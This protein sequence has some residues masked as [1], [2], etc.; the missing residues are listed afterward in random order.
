MV[1]F[2]VLACLTLY[3]PDCFP[4]SDPFF[5]VALR[6]LFFQ[7]LP[8][9]SSSPRVSLIWGVEPS[10]KA[11]LFVNDFSLCDLILSQ[12]CQAYLSKCFHCDIQLS[13]Q[14]QY[15]FFFKSLIFPLVPEI[16]SS[17]FPFPSSVTPLFFLVTQT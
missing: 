17:Q 12:D 14:V 16:S 15:F 9:G 7:L 8:L 3:L 6:C 4:A 13:P 2:F 5:S 10:M 11:H 1:S